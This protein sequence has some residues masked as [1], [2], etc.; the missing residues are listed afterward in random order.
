M[1]EARRSSDKRALI[2]LIFDSLHLIVLHYGIWFGETERRLGLKKAIEVDDVVWE[3]VLSIM[4]ERI[5]RRCKVPTE[6]GVLEFFAGMDKEGLSAL[7]VDMGKNWLA[8]D[9]VWFQ[10]VEKD[11]M[12]GAR[13]INDV[14]WARFSY[15]EAKRIMKRLDLPESGGLTALKKAL[16]YRQYALVNRQEIVDAADNRI[17]F[18][19]NECR[20]QQARKRA[21]LPDYPCKSVGVVEYT[22]FTE[23][24]DPRIKTACLG[25]PPDPHPAEWY[26]A[27]EFIL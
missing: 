2:D 25:C 3:R 24:I 13:Q 17:I 5:A 23:G 7:L 27:W 18:R 1:K 10:A 6:D 20:V 12:E 21:G 4:L 9:G 15:I 26:C 16:K 8:S 14:C 22:R 11:G 19:M